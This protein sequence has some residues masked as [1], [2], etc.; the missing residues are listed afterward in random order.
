MAIEYSLKLASSA[1]PSGIVE[2]VRES[3]GGV[4]EPLPSGA[5]IRLSAVHC[6]V[7]TVDAIDA[8]IAEESYG[9]RPSITVMFRIDKD[10]REEGK[11]AMLSAVT[12]I[13]DAEPG[14]AVLLANLEHPALC[15]R[16]G[17][18]VLVERFGPW[19]ASMLGALGPAWSVASELPRPWAPAL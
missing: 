13:L 2:L 15:R 11:R 8:E 17:R 3:E 19:P 16:G 10:R 9:I 1:L 6:A 4:V 7:L 5:A 18:G 12:R 14:D